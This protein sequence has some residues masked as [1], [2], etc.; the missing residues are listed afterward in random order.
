MPPVPW[1]EIESAFAAVR[2]AEP[3]PMLKPFALMPVSGSWSAAYSE[4]F[5]Y[6]ELKGPNGQPR[7][8]VR[9]D[10][11]PGAVE[12]MR[13]S[14]KECDLTVTLSCGN[15]VLHTSSRGLTVLDK[16]TEKRQPLP[17]IRAE[18]VRLLG[19]AEGAAAYD[20]LASVM[21]AGP[22]PDKRPYRAPIPLGFT[23]PAQPLPVHRPKV[24][25]SATPEFGAMSRL[26]FADYN[27]AQLAESS[28]TGRALAMVRAGAWVILT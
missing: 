3:P 24:A 16:R 25:K 18:L 9:K 11:K 14:L 13:I 8:R 20:A 23:P 27:A 22:R 26:E 5:F 1:T 7:R 21:P 17:L 4:R 19:A 28:E 12:T 6:V 10:G 2:A 15:F